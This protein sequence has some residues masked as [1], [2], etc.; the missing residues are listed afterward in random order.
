[1]YQTIQTQTKPNLTIPNQAKL[2]A[3]PL[4]NVTY[5]KEDNNLYYFIKIGGLNISLITWFYGLIILGA[6]MTSKIIH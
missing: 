4:S 5:V 6:K 2:P 3:G 1:M